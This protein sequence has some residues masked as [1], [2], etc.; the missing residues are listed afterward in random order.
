MF[1]EKGCIQ[2]LFYTPVK[3]S[4]YNSKEK[5]DYFFICRER[6]TKTVEDL[7]PIRCVTAQIWKG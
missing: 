3:L 2:N 4:Q 1:I 7:H 5:Q 6:Y